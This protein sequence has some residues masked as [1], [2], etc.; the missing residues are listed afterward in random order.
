MTGEPLVYVGGYSEPILF[1][2]GQVLQGK[3]KGLYHFRLDARNG[4]LKRDGL[5]ENVRNPS[6]LAFDPKRRFLYCVNEFKEY[7]GQA[8]GAVSAFRIDPDSGAL[9]YLNT[10]ASRGADPCHLIVDATGKFALIANFASGS[11]CVLPILPDGSLGDAVEFIQHEGS[12]ID[13]KRQAGPHAH[14]VEIDKANRFVFVPDL[15]L[16]QIVIYAFDASTGKLTLNANQPFVAMAPGAGPRQLAF[17]PGGR[18]A[19]LINE[20]NSTMTAYSYD[21]ERGALTE[22][23][24][25]PTLPAGFQGHSTC[26][27]VQVA[28]NGKFLYGSNRGHDSIAIYALSKDGRMN[29][30][31]HES[32]RGRIP[33]NFDISPDGRFLA[34]A[35]QDTGDIVMFRIDNESGRLT[36]TGDV[37]EA[38]TPVCVRFMS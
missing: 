10:K 36:A 12:S 27:E 17:H 20:L 28:P 7:E 26:A 30:V 15:G 14:A 34:A 35:N 21:A 3:G 23:Q 18:L 38:G 16:D 31:G 25:L 1:G 22:L 29:V 37:V 8:S 32:T 33:R 24:T 5:T 4:A 2:T 9:T 13:P 11:V 19:Y 6:Y